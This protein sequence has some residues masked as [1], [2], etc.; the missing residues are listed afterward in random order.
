MLTF[1]RWLLAGLL[2]LSFLVGAVGCKSRGGKSGLDYGIYD[3]GTQEI[4]ENSVLYSIKNQGGNL[5]VVVEY[6]NFGTVDENTKGKVKEAIKKVIKDWNDKLVGYGGW[7]HKDIKVNFVSGNYCRKG[8]RFWSCDRNGKVKVIIDS[9]IPRS[10]GNMWGSMIAIAGDNIADLNYIDVGSSQF[11][12]LVLH[13]YGHLLG[14]ADLY[15]E[16]G[17]QNPLNQPESIMKDVHTNK[18]L[19]SD[20]QAGIRALW[21]YL[22]GHNDQACSVKLGYEVGENIGGN[23][24]AYYCVPKIP[25][26]PEVPS[27][28]EISENKDPAVPKGSVAFITKSGDAV[29]HASSIPAAGG[30]EIYKKDRVI[31]DKDKFYFKESEKY[32]GAYK[33]ISAKYNTCLHASGSQ[34]VYQAKAFNI[35]H[36][37]CDKGDIR[38]N[39]WLL[40]FTDKEKG[41]FKLM[42]HK[43]ELCLH[44][45]SHIRIGKGGREGP[46]QI[47]QSS[48]EENPGDIMRYQEF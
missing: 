7:S 6:Q 2:F 45:S 44:F 48:C 20:D 42:N 30:G 3:V 35:Y 15:A 4:R 33:I 16:V 40:S 43:T 18:G 29:I 25:K 38:K 14:L 9:H 36:K 11:Y 22:E 32:P 37:N 13:E 8:D 23:G 26:T 34:V 17:R 31:D 27:S 5:D 21:D 1:F 24:R 19:T 41:E 12:R 47:Y 46:L 10:Y 39:L 28:L